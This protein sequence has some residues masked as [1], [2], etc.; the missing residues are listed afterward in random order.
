MNVDYFAGQANRI[1]SAVENVS[2]SFSVR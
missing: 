2:L 1:F